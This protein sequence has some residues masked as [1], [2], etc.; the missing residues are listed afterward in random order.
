VDYVPALERHYPQAPKP[1]IVPLW[2][3]ASGPA[4]QRRLDRH[5]I[6]ICYTGI[7]AAGR[8]L[9]RFVTLLAQSAHAGRIEFHIFGAQPEDRIAVDPAA[10]SRLRMFA[11][12]GWRSEAALARELEAFHFGAVVTDPALTAPSFPSKSLLYMEL[13]LPIVALVPPHSEFAR[14]VEELYRCGVVLDGQSPQRLDALIDLL[15]KDESQYEQLIRN[16][17]DTLECRH[18]LRNIHLI[19]DT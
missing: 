13:G 19:L 6:R 18:S 15:L 12:H 5:R 8:Q 17:R 2:R 1:Q 9:D 10:S 3:H 16:A 7:V 4:P 11:V 14:H